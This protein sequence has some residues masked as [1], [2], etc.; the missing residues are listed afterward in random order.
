[1]LIFLATAALIL[2]RRWYLYFVVGYYFSYALLLFVS[3]AK[4]A[5]QG[6]KGLALRR[7]RNLILFGVCAMAAMVVLL[8]PMVSKILAFNYSDRYSYYNVG[9]IAVE[10][11]YH[12]MRTGLLNLILILFGLWLCVK[13]K[14][15][16]CLCWRCVS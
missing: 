16:A 4:L 2:S 5:K 13:R 15:P 1:M 9:G 8:W 7:V 14:S 6:Q 12:A 10:L 3:S 11:Y